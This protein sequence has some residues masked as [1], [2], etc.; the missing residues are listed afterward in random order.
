MHLVIASTV[1]ATAFYILDEAVG[2]CAIP[3]VFGRHLHPLHYCMWLCT[4]HIDILTVYAQA[5]HQVSFGAAE[6]ASN[7]RQLF[8]ALICS[9]LI[10]WCGFFG[11]YLDWG[12]GWTLAFLSGAFA[13]FAVTVS[14]VNRM[15]CAMVQN[16]DGARPLVASAKS[17]LTFIRRAISIKWTMYTV[18]WSLSTVGA[19]SI[20]TE[21]ILLTT[22]DVL[23]AF[24]ATSAW[25][26]TL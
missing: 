7:S 26:I 14:F 16:V 25:A 15:M 5:S 10:F 20:G 17:Q 21:G 24:L 1:G 23:K 6:R 12:N 8:S 3:S 9:H 19:I 22:L 11:N 2:K 4:M 18:I 13:S